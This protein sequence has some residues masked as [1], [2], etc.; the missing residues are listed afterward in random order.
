VPCTK[1][2]PRSLAETRVGRLTRVQLFALAAAGVGLYPAVND[3]STLNLSWTD[4]SGG[5]AQFS[6][7]RKT[8]TTG[9]YGEIGQQAAG[10]TSYS[11]GTV[12]DGTTYCYRVRAFNNAGCR[13]IPTRLAAAPRQVDWR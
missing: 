12:T 3:A 9:I 8:G 4:T 6:I 11:D 13:V 5:V 10:I 7:E 2:V 1:P